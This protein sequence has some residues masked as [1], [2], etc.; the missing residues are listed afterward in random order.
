ANATLERHIVYRF[1]AR[2]VDTWR[3]GRLLLAGDAAHLMPPFAGQGMCS[4]LRD[5]ANLEWK[6]DLILT[7]RADERILDSYGPERAEH[8]RHF[9]DASMA[10]GS[11]ICVTDP[12]AADQRDAAMRVDL[13]AGVEQPP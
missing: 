3:Y 1:Q 13:A 11:V 9:I 4:G 2:W 7:G 8:V 5:A 10:L 6:L 12:A